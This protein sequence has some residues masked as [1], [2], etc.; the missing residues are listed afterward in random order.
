M[1]YNSQY[2][3]RGKKIQDTYQQILQYDSGS[4]TSYLGKGDSVTI[5]SDSASLADTASYS[6]NV[7]SASY[8]KSA[9]WADKSLVSTRVDLSNGGGLNVSTLLIYNAG[10]DDTTNYYAQIGSPFVGALILANQSQSRFIRLNTDGNSYIGTQPYN[11]GIGTESPTAK[12]HVVGN[13][14]ASSITASLQGTSSWANTS[15][16]ASKASSLRVIDSNNNV[17]ISTVIQSP[18]GTPDLIVAD[19]SSNQTT[20]IFP[21]G[22][23]L[24]DTN[25]SQN[26]HFVTN[27]KSYIQTSYN[28]GI[29]TDS[30]TAKLHVQGNIS[31]SSVTSSLLGTAS[32]AITASYA[33]NALTAG[34]ATTAT[35]ATTAATASYVLNAVSSSY[36]TNGL[37]S[38]YAI[39]ASYALSVLSA[40]YA[41]SAAGGTTIFTSSLYQI[42]SSWAN[43]AVSASYVLNA[44]SSSYSTN[45]STASFYNGSVTSASYA[46]T[47]T[48]CSGIVKANQYAFDSGY[49]NYYAASVTASAV[50]DGRVMVF[51]TGSQCILTGS[52]SST[53]STMI[54]QSG[55]STITI[56][57]SDASIV[58]RN[59]QS[60]K[61]LAG[62]YAVASVFRVS[63]GDFVLAGDLA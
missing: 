21:S 60:F 18:S 52:L 44:V 9:S 23:Y 46:T 17:L 47:A 26:I 22:L 37:S 19:S 49:A 41:P 51:T 57:G 16:W 50:D 30:P 33:L 54:Y 8:A 63:N 48:T 2:D 31:A 13:I 3:L 24:T 15:S 5:N 43:N 56:T 39:T 45:S 32:W 38:S 55:S 58:L 29:G 12:L 40:S 1:P 6:L 20:E 53:F 61:A 10:V 28:F 62:Q 42:T 14:L 34:T 59:R 36:S 11:F 4:E 7:L 35:S 25:L 27:D